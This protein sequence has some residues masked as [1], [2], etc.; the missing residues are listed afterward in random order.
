[1][2]K[3]FIIKD[4]SKTLAEQINNT[5]LIERTAMSTDPITNS[6]GLSAVIPKDND[7]YL[8]SIKWIARMGL[9]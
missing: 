5:G 6:K 7:G 8:L 9:V 4:A 3:T 1:M 2:K